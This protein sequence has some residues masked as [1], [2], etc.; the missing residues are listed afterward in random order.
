MATWKIRLLVDTLKKGDQVVVAKDDDGV[1]K[2]G[3]VG[4]ERGDEIVWKHKG[5]TDKAFLVTF[6]NFNSGAAIWPF[7]GDPD[8]DASK[9]LRVP[10]LAPGQEPVKK[11]IKVRVPVKYEVQV[12]NDNEVLPLDPMIIVRDSSIAAML[13]PVLASGLMGALAGAFLSWVALRGM[14]AG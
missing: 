8:I 14:G 9:A 11:T 3:N 6:V 1:K 5:G 7:F 12:E 10:V 4:A 2:G 13:I